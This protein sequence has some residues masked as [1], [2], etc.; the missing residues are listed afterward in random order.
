MNRTKVKKLLREFLGPTLVE[1]FCLRGNFLTD[2][3]GTGQRRL[4]G[5]HSAE[6]EREERERREKRDR[7]EI[8]IDR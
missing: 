6:R 3:I 8:E 5:G 2:F 1:L 7:R 4:K